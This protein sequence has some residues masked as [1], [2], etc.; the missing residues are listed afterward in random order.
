MTDSILQENGDETL[1]EN[2]GSFVRDEP[3][4]VTEHYAHITG[5]I[6]DQVIVIKTSTLQSAGGWYVSGVFKPASEWVKTSYNTMGG[7]HRLGG[8]PL[9][10]NFS[11]IG[12]SYDA[13]SD[14]FIPPKQF[15]SWILNETSGINEPPVSYPNDGQDYRWDEDTLSWVLTS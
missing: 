3:D 5:G 9:R 10:K 2:G 15:S 13:G 7:T 12:F 11:G 4:N 8:V 14:S 1:Q 6:V